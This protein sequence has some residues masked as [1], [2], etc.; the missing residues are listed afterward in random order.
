MI[1]IFNDEEMNE[2]DNKYILCL[3]IDYLI[4]TKRFSGALY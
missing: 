2:S 1:K 4:Q 3:F